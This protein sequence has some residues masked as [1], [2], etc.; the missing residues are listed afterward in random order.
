V[1]C[2]LA[3]LLAEVLLAEV[4]MLLLLLLLLVLLLSL[5]YGLTRR[6]AQPRRAAS[7]RGR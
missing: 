2:L 7:L 5:R 3:E 4:L 1:L 6:W